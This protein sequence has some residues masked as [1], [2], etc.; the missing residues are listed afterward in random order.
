MV[1]NITQRL[2]IPLLLSPL[3]VYSLVAQ[4]ASAHHARQPLYRLP[5]VGKG[6]TA[7]YDPEHPFDAVNR[8]VQFVNLTDSAG[9]R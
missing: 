8:R 4:A 7:L 3:L 6:K 2:L 5:A 1:I 9:R